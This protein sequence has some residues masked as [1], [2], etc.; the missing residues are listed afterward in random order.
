MARHRAD[1][2]R[3]YRLSWLSID[4][5][6]KVARFLIAFCALT[7]MTAACDREASNNGTSMPPPIETGASARPG[8]DGC[9]LPPAVRLSPATG[10][11]TAIPIAALPPEIKPAMA[12]L[13][14]RLGVR[15]IGVLAIECVQWPDGC[16]GYGGADEM[17]TQALV[18]G[19]RLTLAD[20]SL[21][22]SRTYEYH[23][24]LQGNFRAPPS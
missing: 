24:D 10:Q 8:I 9:S 16:L 21:Q 15:S 11:R 4:I 5:G 23:T 1:Y 3:R 19:Y 13:E 2:N 14:E 22:Q 17:C 6:G 18:P 20:L 12:D 7:V